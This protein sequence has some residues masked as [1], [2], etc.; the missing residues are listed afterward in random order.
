MIWRLPS[1]PGNACVRRAAWISSFALRTYTSA[2]G[3]TTSSGRSRAR[4]SCWVIVDA[5][6][7]G[8]CEAQ[9]LGDRRRATAVA[10]QRLHGGRPH[11]LHVEPLVGPERPVLGARRRIEDELRYRIVRDHDALLLLESRE[12]VRPRAV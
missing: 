11:R 5:R 8:P 12:L 3:A 10:V 2:P 4:T 6:G 1:S 7:R 9:L